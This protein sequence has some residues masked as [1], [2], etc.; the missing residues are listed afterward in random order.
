MS[1]DNSCRYCYGIQRLMLRVFGVAEARIQR[2]EQGLLDAEIDP[3]AKAALEFARR[4][5]RAA[6]LVSGA[7]AEAL[8]ATGWS[9]IAI[10]ELAFESS[11]TTCS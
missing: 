3:R 9:P 11:F 5:S 2:L 1:Q 8:L 7:D 10:R 6:P 4:V